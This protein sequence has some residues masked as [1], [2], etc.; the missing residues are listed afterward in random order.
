MKINQILHLHFVDV[1]TLRPESPNFI[2]SVNRL[3]GHVIDGEDCPLVPG[4]THVTGEKHPSSRRQAHDEYNRFANLIKSEGS[5]HNVL[6]SNNGRPVFDLF[7]AGI[8]ATDKI[9]YIKIY[10]VVVIASIYA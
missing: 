7:S 6:T 3:N 10:G 4:P 2:R 9:M 1:T 5:G 8:T